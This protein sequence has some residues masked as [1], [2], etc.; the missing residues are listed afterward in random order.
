[1]SKIIHLDSL[2]WKPVR[3]DISHGVQGKILAH[4]RV[5]VVHTRVAPDGGFSPH[6]DSHAHLL[7]FLSGTGTVR[8]GDQEFDARTG[9]VVQISSGE[10]HSYQ[11]TGADDLILL[12]MNLPEPK[13]A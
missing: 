7:Y 9:L 2:D 5:K 11:N 3:P 1:M 8:V 12:S 6:R 13:S 4:D 10:E